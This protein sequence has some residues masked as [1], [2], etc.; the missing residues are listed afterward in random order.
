M[1]FLKRVNVAC[2]ALFSDLERRDGVG[3]GAD[4][5]AGAGGWGSIGCWSCGCGGL[6]FSMQVVGAWGSVLGAGA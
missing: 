5:G 3:V 4:A 2:M 1:L 6:G